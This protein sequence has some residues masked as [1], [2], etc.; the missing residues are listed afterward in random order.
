MYVRKKI[1]VFL[2]FSIFFIIYVPNVRMGVGLLCATLNFREVSWCFLMFPDVFIIYVPNVRTPSPAV[3]NPK[4]S[5][6]FL[7]ISWCFHHYVPNVRMGWGCC[8]KTQTFL[9]FHDVTLSFPKF[10]VIFMILYETLRLMWEVLDFQGFIGVF[11]IIYGDIRK[12]ERHKIIHN[13]HD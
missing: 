2:M 8:A 13:K 6:S 5:W 11:E 7:K 1:E 9:K 3:R 4:L 10:I 12:M